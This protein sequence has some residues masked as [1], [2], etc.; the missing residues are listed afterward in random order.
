MPNGLGRGFKVG[1]I[2]PRQSRFA[3]PAPWPVDRTVRKDAGT[4]LKSGTGQKLVVWLCLIGALI[5]AAD[6]H[7]TIAGAK[8]T[9]GRLMVFL[10]LGP[11]L[12]ILLH[13]K[14]R[15]IFGDAVAVMI[16]GWMV[17]AAWVVGGRGTMTSTIA[18]SLELVGGYLAARAFLFGPVVLNEFVRVLRVVV[19][20]TVI[21]ALAEH[22]TG[23]L[24]L[25]DKIAGL[26]NT[27]PP[28]AQ[29]REGFLRS[30]ATFDHA[31]L[32][33]T[34]CAVSATIFLYAER[35]PIKR[36]FSVG[37]CALGALLSL[38]SSALMALTI[39]GAAFIYDRI[40]RQ[41][42]WRWKM[43]MLLVSLPIL[44]ISALSNNPLGWVLSHLTLN[45][46]SGYFRLMIWHAALQRISESPLVGYG[47]NPLHSGI[48]DATVDSV[49]LV[50][51]LRFG[52]PVTILMVVWN[53]T[54]W[55]LAPAAAPGIPR[56]AP[57]TQAATGFT[58]ALM[59]FMFIGLT[60]H[61]WN[62]VWIFWGLC[63]GIRASVYE[64]SLGA[65]RHATLSPVNL[66]AG[67]AVR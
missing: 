59:I 43:F 3:P 40:M 67:H 20:V 42:P 32:Y 19:I 27:I 53:L 14:R 65:R 52:L 47:F 8:F 63:I 6:V 56:A 49:W 60:V 11:A 37:L 36:M 55:R 16:G 48:L 51:T 15:L 62:Y 58:M 31:I 26:L 28:S 4:T 50:T 57:L 33:G 22:A 30:I 17:F 44:A 46:V 2:L 25:N 29:F 24:I 64:W 54:V 7:F 13:P 41:Y 34:F 23:R 10:L 39:V 61:F 12:A 66:V 45:P 35:D 21:V 1:A 38:S 18:E 9:V 5:P